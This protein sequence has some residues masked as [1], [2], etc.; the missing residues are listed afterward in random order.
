MKGPGNGPSTTGEQPMPKK[1][2]DARWT[3]ADIEIANEFLSALNN[4]AGT[5]NEKKDSASRSLGYTGGYMSLPQG[6]RSYISHVAQ[7]ARK[8]R[9]NAQRDARVQGYLE[10]MREDWNHQYETDPSFRHGMTHPEDGARRD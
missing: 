4:F 9:D 8:T 2:E 1:V 7:E 3:E 10:L 6:V 5:F